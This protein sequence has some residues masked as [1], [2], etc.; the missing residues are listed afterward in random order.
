MD[1]E[2]WD[3]VRRILAVRL[4][5]VGDVIM[6]GPALRAMRRRIPGVSISL[7][8]S[9]AGA[10]A[11][12]LLDDVDE[13]ISFRAP[14]QRALGTDAEEDG[15]MILA[16]VEELRV[17][18]FDTAVIFTSFSQSPHPA[19]QVCQLA[20]IP[21]RLAQSKESAGTTLTHWV[22]PLAD[23]IHQVDR[24][25]YLMRTAG[26]RSIDQRLHVHVPTEARTTASDLLAEKG[27]GAEEPL[28]LVLP[29]ASCA[30]RRWD[31]EAFSA[32]ASLVAD[33]GIRVVTA[34]SER[35]KRLVDEVA[36]AA[37][38]GVSLGGRTSL[39]ELAALVDRA[40]V[41]VANNSAGLHLADALATPVVALYSG[42]E[43]AE[44]WRPRFTRSSVLNR[45]MD[46]APCHLFEC[47][48]GMPCL[49]VPPEEVAA[50]AVELL[51]SSRP[52]LAEYARE[53]CLAGV[54]AAS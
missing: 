49:E 48:R 30:A 15:E 16:L 42:A 4:D 23:D 40:D 27:I 39:A 17:R 33:A 11:A 19:A 46:C 9:P 14:W 50:R 10:E 2:E 8:T 6:L 7:L 25:L 53:A 31:G 5:N 3:D 26:L 37:S 41:V 12:A 1:P 13:S 52:E 24:N 28:A 18:E 35:E 47:P 21:R 54:G 44:Q 45:E 43:H 29:G 32:V 38:D 34:G 22:M 51:A 20:G 36:G